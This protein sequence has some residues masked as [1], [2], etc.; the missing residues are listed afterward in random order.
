M[1]II[2]NPI[3]GMNF[4]QHHVNLKL[5]HSGLFYVNSSNN[6]I[7]DILLT[8]D[9]KVVLDMM[10][11]DSSI[12]HTKDN[13][14]EFMEELEKSERFYRTAFLGAFRNDETFA[15]L[16]VVTKM[17]AFLVYPDTV[18]TQRTTTRFTDNEIHK[19]FPHLKQAIITSNWYLDNQRKPHMAMNGKI[20]KK[21]FPDITGPEIGEV[22]N[23]WNGMDERL[24]VD[25]FMNNSVRE[26]IKEIRFG[27]VSIHQLKQQSND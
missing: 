7:D 5:T 11:M 17:Y 27:A 9:H 1:Y 3:L 12:E 10:G 20:I 18:I 4:H 22:M 2:G 23:K 13:D 6:L 26:I 8:S 25:I 19:L 21:Y 16:P 24:R 14:I 15:N